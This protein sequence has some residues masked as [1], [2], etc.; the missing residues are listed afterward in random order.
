[1]TCASHAGKLP[2][3][4]PAKEP[5]RLDGARRGGLPRADPPAGVRCWER[6]ALLAASHAVFF[7]GYG[8]L[9]RALPA[10]GAHD[11]TTAWDAALPFVPEFVG[12]FALAY[13][14]VGLPALVVRSRRR[15]S[16][17]EQHAGR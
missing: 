7:L 14:F 10:A 3:I 5:V 4:V 12:P 15:H 17:G 1:L 2:V 13:L 9:N 6:L 16:Q 11:L 8:A